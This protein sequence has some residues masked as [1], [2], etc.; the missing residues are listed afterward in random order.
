[1]TEPSNNQRQPI[2]M[3]WVAVAIAVSIALYTVINIQFRKDEA[4]HLP[5]E[6]AQERKSQ[7]FEF[8][9]NGW[10]RLEAVSRATNSS[11]LGVDLIS[12]SERSLK[13]RLDQEL[14]MDLVTVIPERPE[15]VDGIRTVEPFLTEE[16]ILVIE[17]VLVPESKRPI[18]LDAYLKDGLLVMLA[19]E[20]ER[21]A[22][23]AGPTTFDLRVSGDGFPEGTYSTALYT[24]PTIYEWT[25][26]VD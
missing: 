14:P 8:D 21:F 15:L 12:I 19:D 2:P 3:A 5:Y 24:D 1:M 23:S 7:L 16:R 20:G 4:P 6:E 11:N 13:G 10:Q 22:E 26:T 17:F 25:F 18:H 9:M